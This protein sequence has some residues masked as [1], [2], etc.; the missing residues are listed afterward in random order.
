[1][2][3]WCFY[4][5]SVMIFFYVL[6]FSTF[7]SEEVKLDKRIYMNSKKKY[8]PP[9]FLCIQNEKI[10]Y[11]C[12]MFPSKN[13]IRILCTYHVWKSECLSLLQKIKSLAFRVL[14]LHTKKDEE[15]LNILFT[16]VFVWNIWNCFPIQYVSKEKKVKKN[17]PT[18]A[19]S[20]VK[21]LKTGIFCCTIH[22]EFSIFFVF[23]QI[24]WN[25]FLF[26]Q[27]THIERR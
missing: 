24:L 23:H 14:V 10:L 13:V 5:Q 25:R 15:N 1:M 21:N 11:V 22:E 16:V 19:K 26:A 8:F 27:N 20:K 17:L 9:R 3:M 7:W 18:K 4:P 12:Q 6:H 2:K